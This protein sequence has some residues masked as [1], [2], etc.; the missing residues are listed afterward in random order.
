VHS[1]QRLD[2]RER[3]NFGTS[4]CSFCDVNFTA[5]IPTKNFLVKQS[6]IFQGLPVN[7]DTDKSAKLAGLLPLKL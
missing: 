2:K 4:L 6:L 3:I 7:G 1:I 5:S